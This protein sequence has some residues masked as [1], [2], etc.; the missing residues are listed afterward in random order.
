MITEHMIAEI[1]KFIS[2]HVEDESQFVGL[3]EKGVFCDEVNI[4]HINEYAIGLNVNIRCDK[5]KEKTLEVIKITYGEVTFNKPNDTYDSRSFTQS[6]LNLLNSR[7]KC[8]LN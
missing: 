6:E 1:K 2:E 4:S 7:L 3:P 8:N 5:T